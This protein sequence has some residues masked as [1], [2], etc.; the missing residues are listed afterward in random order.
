M[1]A[2]PELAATPDGAVFGS[3]ERGRRSDVHGRAPGPARRNRRTIRR[4]AEAAREATR[5]S[6]WRR[7]EVIIANTFMCA[8]RTIAIPSPSRSELSGLPAAQGRAD[9]GARD[10]LARRLLDESCCAVH[11]IQDITR[12]CTG[13][14]RCSRW[15]GAR[16]ALS[17]LSPAAT[18]YPSMLEA[19]R[20][21]FVRLPAA[22]ARV[23]PRTAAGRAAGDRTRSPPRAHHGRDPLP[24]A[25]SAPPGEFDH[26][27]C[28]TPGYPE[29]RFWT[30]LWTRL[31]RLDAC[32]RPVYQEKKLPP[33]VNSWRTVLK[34]SRDDCR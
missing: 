17:D 25:N 5:E 23:R 31:D 7:W 22:C 11:P 34:V 15:A 9:P 2:L 18:L 3:G 28:S 14:P 1:R 24:R 27:A 10:L 26:W 20:E 21:D 19:L 30:P 4:Y 6:G 8:S 32:F 12:R 13:G 29:G 16:R 33:N